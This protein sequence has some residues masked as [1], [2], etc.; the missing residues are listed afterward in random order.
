MHCPNCG[1]EVSADYNVCPNCGTNLQAYQQQAGQQQAYQQQSYD[2]NQ[3]FQQAYG[4]AQGYQ[5]AYDPNQQYQQAYGQAQGYQQGYAQNQQYQA[6]G[7][8][9]GY[10]TQKKTNVPLIILIVVLVL[11][12]LGGG[13]FGVYKYMESQNSSAR[14]SRSRD[15][16][17]DKDEDEDEDEEDDED[18]DDRDKKKKDK[19]DEDDEEDFDDGG[20]ATPVE[21]T[22][23]IEA[24]PASEA[25][26]ASSGYGESQ[27]K[28]V[29][30]D[31]MPQIL[32]CVFALD[33]QGLN[34]YFEAHYPEGFSA[35]ISEL[36]MQ[37][38]DMD[39][40]EKMISQASDQELEE[41]RS[42]IDALKAGIGV[43]DCKPMSAE[44]LADM[45]EDISEELGGSIPELTDGYYVTVEGLEEMFG[46][47]ET[48]FTVICCDGKWGVYDMEY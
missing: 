34:R 33:K 41:M 11:A 47:R 40:M 12:L 8:A 48:V 29:A 25:P 24:E 13:G 42:R 36:I 44:E 46:G 21:E 31:M 37:G 30:A 10:G 9:Q 5:Q 27:A 16:D 19:D 45:N 15:K 32:D 17:K 20:S 39:E 28:M 43:S 14:S 23:T 38:M 1:T 4:Q 3:Q 6:Y 2:Q 35:I 7:Q 18:E 22:G 26:A